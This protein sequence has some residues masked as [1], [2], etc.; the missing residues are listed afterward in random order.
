MVRYLY[1][2]HHSYSYDS[3]LA[4]HYAEKF[5]KE[6]SM[7]HGGTPKDLWTLRILSKAMR[8]YFPS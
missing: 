8:Q 4:N 7:L 3:E 6:A 5:R 1:A 2:R